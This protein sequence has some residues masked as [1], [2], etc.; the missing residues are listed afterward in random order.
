MYWE[1]YLKKKKAQDAVL[2]P[3]G[4]NEVELNIL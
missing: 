3:T 4:A 1:F 2:I